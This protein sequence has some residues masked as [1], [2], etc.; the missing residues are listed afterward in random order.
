MK[1]LLR[2][3]LILVAVGLIAAGL[4]WKFYVNKPH[5]DIDNATPAYTME[6]SDL[7]KHF[8]EESKT[9]DSLYTGKVIELSGKLSRVDKNDS[10]V[11]VIFVMAADSMFGDKTISCQMYTKH[12]DE[13]SALAPGS[14]V[15]IKGFCT[16]YNDPDIKFNKC[17]IVK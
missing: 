9:A 12:N 8:T 2:I 1:K 5:E 7:W 15:K 11:S 3:V 10:L 6:T 14:V 17:S 16:G 13:A 4:V